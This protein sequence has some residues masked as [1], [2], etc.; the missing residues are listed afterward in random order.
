[1]KDGSRGK[2]YESGFHVL[3]SREEAE[4]FFKKLFRIYK[5]R[6][7]IKILAKGLKPK[8]HSRHEVFLADEIYVPAHE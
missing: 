8:S 4:K 7:V 3:T 6:K 5:N 1:V 2:Y